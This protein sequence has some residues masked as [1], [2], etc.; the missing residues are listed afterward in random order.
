MKFLEI[1]KFCTE[2]NT[3][4]WHG[5]ASI[6]GKWTKAC[7]IDSH[8]NLEKRSVM[9]TLKRKYDKIKCNWKRKKTKKNQQAKIWKRCDYNQIECD[10]ISCSKK[11][12]S[13]TQTLGMKGFGTEMWLG[14]IC[15]A[16]TMPCSFGRSLMGLVTCSNTAPPPFLAPDCKT[17]KQYFVIHIE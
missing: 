13:E 3:I 12:S 9:N 10:E 2:G 15:I 11:N 5:M 4:K 1:K 7:Q 17:V 16:L 14:R 8:W 6:A